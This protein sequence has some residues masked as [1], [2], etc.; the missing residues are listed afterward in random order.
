MLD[1][2]K[3]EF[4][5]KTRE[6]YLSEI[7]KW[8]NSLMMVTEE[9]KFLGKLLSA[10]IF[11]PN[12][13]NLYE[14]LQQYSKKLQDLKNEEILLEKEIEKHKTDF[15]KELEENEEQKDPLIKGTHI[16][17]KKNITEFLKNNSG[18]KLEIF[19]FTGNILKKSR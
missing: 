9:I 4:S 2:A 18:L 19:N 16:Q 17:L 5:K 12:I 1:S 15:A 3:K 6:K 14:R 7:S 11:E 10:G 13:P 8:E